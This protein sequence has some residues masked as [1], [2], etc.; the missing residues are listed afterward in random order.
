MKERPILFSAPMVRAILD[1]KKTQTRRIVKLPDGHPEFYVDPGGTEVF[2]PGPYL[3]FP[4]TDTQIGH[5]RVRCPYG[6]PG[7]R[8]WVRETHARFVVGEGMDTPVPECVAYRA[9]CD[10][11]GGFDYVNGRGEPMRLKVTKWTPAIHMPRWASRITLEIAEVRVERLHD[12]SEAD[13][14][15]E[16]IDEIDGMLDDAEIRRA[17]KL[18][19][20]SHEDA[21]A[22]FA[23]LW[24][25]INGERR[26][27]VEEIDESGPT[28][29]SR[30][31][32]DRSASW[33][34][35]P[36]VWALTFKRIEAPS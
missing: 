15:A 29:R 1:N 27:R 23:A 5:G 8:L 30:V 13:C 16:G 25:R 26:A 21:R 20:C 7:D 12:I 33:A 11:D 19:G 22:T 9:T 4:A 2:G 31:V 28:G 18:A 24:E 17:A 10:D 36:W 32:V 6:Y 14:W 34:A 35:N 3:K